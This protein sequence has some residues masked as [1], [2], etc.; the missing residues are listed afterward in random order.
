[1]NHPCVKAKSLEAKFTRYKLR[2]KETVLQKIFKK[3]NLEEDDPESTGP[4]HVTKKLTSLQLYDVCF[5]ETFAVEGSFPG[6]LRRNWRE[7]DLEKYGSTDFKDLY[8][9]I[10]R[11]NVNAGGENELLIHRNI[12]VVDEEKSEVSLHHSRFVS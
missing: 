5:S 2:S 4:P 3:Q 11:E 12:E 7:A 10:I 6:I 9:N 8:C 1:M